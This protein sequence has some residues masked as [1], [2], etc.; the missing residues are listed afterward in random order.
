ME[1][2]LGF[3]LAEQAHLNLSER[4]WGL[5]NEQDNREVVLVPKQET[6]LDLILKVLW[7]SFLYLFKQS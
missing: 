3:R 2:V 5:S 1:G 6:I 4:L 7:Y